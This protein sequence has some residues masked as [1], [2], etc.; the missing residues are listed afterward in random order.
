MGLG[1][2]GFREKEDDMTGSSAI[3][4]AP[5]GLA[6]RGRRLWREVQANWELDPIEAVL[7]AELCAAVDQCERIRAEL[8]EAGL[9]VTG[10]AGQP[11]ANPLLARILRGLL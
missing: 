2:N 5:A 10:S 11:R 6:D 3:P 4:R 9:L 1:N 8:T 7:L